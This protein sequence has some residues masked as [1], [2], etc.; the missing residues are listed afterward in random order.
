MYLY[1]ITE[2]KWI[3]EKLHS[4][5]KSNNI[6]YEK[7]MLVNKIGKIQVK[8][9]KAVDKKKTKNIYSEL[10]TIKKKY[11]CEFFKVSALTSEG[12]GEAFRKFL[13]KIHQKKIDEKQNEGVEDVEDLDQ[14]EEDV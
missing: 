4:I 7:C 10:E 14:E 2:A 13:S 12:V 11:K 3:L 1:I 6:F 8:L 5:E 9:D